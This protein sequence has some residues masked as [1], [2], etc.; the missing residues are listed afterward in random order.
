MAAADKMSRNGLV[1]EVRLI[2]P[3]QEKM[4]FIPYIMRTTEALIRLRM[5]SLIRAFVARL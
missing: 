2:V 4:N 5:R 1:S 3:Q